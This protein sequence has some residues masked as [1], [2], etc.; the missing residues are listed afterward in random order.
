MTVGILISQ[1]ERCDPDLEIYICHGSTNE[2][3]EIDD[4]DL[5]DINDAS[6]VHASKPH[7]RPKGVLYQD[8]AVLVAVGGVY[9]PTIKHEPPDWR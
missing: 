8:V 4:D 5:T 7:K 1:L 6:V 9:E 3:W 2:F